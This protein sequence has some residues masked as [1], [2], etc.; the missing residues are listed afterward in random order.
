M[1]IPVH[2][3]EEIGFPLNYPTSNSLERVFSKVSSHFKTLLP[4]SNSF[5]L[6]SFQKEYI[7][8]YLTT[9]KPYC[10]FQ[11]LSNF[12]L[13]GKS[14]FQNIFPLSNPTASFKLFQTSAFPERVFSQIPS[15]FQTLLPLSNSFKLQPLQKEY[16]PKYLS[17]F[18]PFCLLQTFS[19][20][21]LSR[22]SIFPI[23][24]PLSNHSA[25]FK[26]FQTSA[27][28]E[29]IFS[30]ISSRFQTLLPLSNSFKLLPL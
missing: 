25:S 28:V 22:K 11:T 3:S 27:S 16:F 4:L 9:F 18:K 14:I 2:C 26:L 8:K 7:H 19:N 6:L 21:C 10:L 23:I 1:Q 24:F 13:S 17:T 20:F 15:H 30:K 29:R 12:C 5:K